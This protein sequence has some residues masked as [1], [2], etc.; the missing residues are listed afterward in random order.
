[1][2]YHVRVGD[3]EVVVEIDGDQVTVDGR[4]VPAQLT[5]TP[6]SPLMRLTLDGQRHDL[7][8]AGRVGG[9]WHIIDRGTVREI[10]AIDERTRHIRSLAGTGGAELSGGVVKAPMPGLVVRVLVTAGDTVVAGQ[11][12]VVLEAM[13]ME[14]ELKAPAAG[15]VQVVRATAGAAVE[16]GSVLV[17]IGPAS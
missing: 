7:A 3:R 14:N 5:T 17:E 6:G 1:M 2:K 13:K 15:V 9:S 4:L 12:L 8:V 16:K 11:G 10:E